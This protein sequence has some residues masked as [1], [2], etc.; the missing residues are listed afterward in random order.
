MFN[1]HTF[2]IYRLTISEGNK[3]SYEDTTRVISGR[4]APQ[5]IEFGVIAGSGYGK[6]YQLFVT[7]VGLDLIE[8]DRLVEGSDKYEVKGVQSYPHPPRHMEVVLEKVIRQ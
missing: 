8:G 6:T 3:K 2:N 4:L 5:D 7:G 1:N